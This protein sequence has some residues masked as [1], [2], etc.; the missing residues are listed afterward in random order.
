ML[1]CVFTTQVSAITAPQQSIS[2]ASEDD[3]SKEQ[4]T[5]KQLSQETVVPHYSFSFGEING[6]F[7]NNIGIVIPERKT[8]LNFEIYYSANPYFDK[9]FEH[10]IAINAP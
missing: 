5:L 10:H 3:S 1:L 9:L 4:T 7:S 2:S 6:F 8:N